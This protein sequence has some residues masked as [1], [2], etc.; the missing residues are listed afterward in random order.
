MLRYLSPGDLLSDAVG[1][2]DK[3]H[4]MVLRMFINTLVWGAVATV[5]M[6]AIL[7]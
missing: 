4:R 5:V 2:T 1:L 7:A 6:I 3:E